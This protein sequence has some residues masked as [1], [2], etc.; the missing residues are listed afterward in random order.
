MGGENLSLYAPYRALFRH[1]SPS[2]ENTTSTVPRNSR[3]STLSIHRRPTSTRPRP[4]LDQPPVKRESKAHM[5]QDLESFHRLILYVIM[6]SGDGRPFS[7]HVATT[8]S[9]TLDKTSLAPPASLPP[10][11]PIKGQAWPLRGGEDNRQQQKTSHHP[12]VDQHLKQS[13]LYS[14]FF[15]L[16]PGIDSFSHSL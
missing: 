4:G 11:D 14:H 15:S 5:P 8:A 7:G 13:P 2:R 9:T 6:V 3:D 10:L 16:R 12:T 1:W